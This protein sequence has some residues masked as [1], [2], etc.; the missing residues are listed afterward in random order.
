MRTVVSRD[1]L[2]TVW[3]D[4]DR[5]AAEEAFDE[6]T[7]FSKLQTR[8]YYRIT[9]GVLRSQTHTEWTIAG[10]LIGESVFPVLLELQIPEVDYFM[11]ICLCDVMH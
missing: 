1:D 3:R 2:M 11:A 9:H 7:G 4:V 10:G 8:G 6:L 5:R